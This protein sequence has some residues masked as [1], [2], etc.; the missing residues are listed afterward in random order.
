[1]RGVVSASL[2]I[3]GGIECTINRVGARFYDQLARCGHY[4]RLDADL[5]A[6]AALGIRALRYPVLW[7]RVAPDG[8]DRADWSTADAALD[9]LKRRNIEP[10]VGLVHHGS[11]P[12]STHLLD[13][14]F[15]A[16][17]AAFARAVAERYP[18]VRLYTPVNEPL[19]TARFAALYGHWYPHRADDEA[20]VAALINEC[21]ATVLAM[22]AIR[23][24]QPEAAL[25][26][27]E[28][29]GSTRSTPALAAQAEFENAR[30]WVGVDLLTGRVT[31]EHPLW[32]YLA[33]VS[34]PRDLEW[35][36]DRQVQPAILG[37]NYYVTSDRY[38]DERLHRYPAITHGGNGR[39]RYAD[40][41]AARVDGIGIRGHAA[42][43]EEAWQ[44]YGIPVAVTEAHLGCT[45]EEQM[46]WLVAAWN[47]ASVAQRR[48]VDVRA[49]TAW[50]LLGSW[51][52]DSLVTDS[53]GHYESGAFDVRVGAPR[54]TALA[55]VIRD[56][57]GG[58]RPD[59]PVLHAPGWWETVRPSSP[60]GAAAH[61]GP[62]A[63]VL[64]IGAT[65]T[66]GRAFIRECEQRRIHYV[67]VS[68][69]QLDITDADAVRACVARV[70][71][72]AI[73]NAAG[74]VRVDDAEQEV[75][76]CR[77][78]NAVAPA[79]LAVVCRK[80]GIR[81]ITF[82]SD[83]VFDGGVMR[84]YVESDSVSPLNVYGRTKAEAERRVLALAPD[85]LVVRTSAFFGPHDRHNF[86]T[87]ALD[88]IAGGGPFRAADDLTV[89]PTYVP[90]LVTTALDLLIDGASGM[91]HLANDG[92]VTW[93]DFAQRAASLAH[94]DPTR[95][96]PCAADALGLAAP[97]PRY[98][99]LASAHG[100]LMSPLDDSLARYF[101][102]RARLGTAA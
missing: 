87:I 102:D 35:F 1:M 81:L 8:L 36:A 78:V 43:L 73:V 55:S 96:V 16:G 97:R 99:V 3:W 45:R 6:L 21:T 83:L 34:E 7:E 64:I 11:G 90:D 10:I 65:G 41:A 14:G 101:H 22:S 26:H 20:F 63:P 53:A 84:P 58:R 59:H 19:T 61:L 39:I 44:R 24:V 92:A 67:A 47:G 80:A 71:P 37:L 93:F 50:A 23:A 4:D 29:A 18:W 48:G 40:V 86:V 28:D 9:G 82:S 85:A 2:E 62:A 100:R 30:R 17:L 66:L 54:P 57:A 95:I 70:R 25:V 51:D 75:R 52:W 33:S 5:D 38:L 46:R 77:K 74:H 68:R 88:A 76:A 56:L 89:S 13:D 60:F 27:T 72:W 15:A 94:L 91:W 98:S 69:P 32:P 49:V 79:I 12:A 31:R 42:V